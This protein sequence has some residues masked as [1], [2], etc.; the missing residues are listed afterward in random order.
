MS[1]TLEL[2]AAEI[3]GTAIGTAVYFATSAGQRRTKVS[4]VYSAIEV[5]GLAHVGYRRNGD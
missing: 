4:P 1:G 3:G 2:F 5:K